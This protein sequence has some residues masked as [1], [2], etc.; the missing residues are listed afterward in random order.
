[1]KFRGT[2]TAWNERGFGFIR[3]DDKEP[4]VFLHASELRRAHVQG[5]VAAGQRIAFDLQPSPK[6]KGLCA[7]NIHLLDPGEQADGALLL[8]QVFK[9]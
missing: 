2:V 7:S 9:R 5:D 1:M 4:D 8:D 6:G 3:R